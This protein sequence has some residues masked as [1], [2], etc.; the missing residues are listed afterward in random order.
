MEPFVTHQFPIE[1]IQEAFDLAES[2]D[3]GALKVSLTFGT[4][5]QA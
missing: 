5:Q 2:P 4:D 3:D 1:K